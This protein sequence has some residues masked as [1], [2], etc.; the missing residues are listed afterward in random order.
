MVS[1]CGQVLGHSF[2]H[3]YCHN[4]GERVIVRSDFK[5]L[6]YYL[7]D[8]GRRP[9]CGVQVPNRGKYVRR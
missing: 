4:C 9:K 1:V 5:V 3:T 2:S 8:D 6:G 7:S